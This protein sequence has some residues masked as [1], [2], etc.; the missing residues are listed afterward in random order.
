MALPLLGRGFAAGAV[1]AITAPNIGIS[2]PG[3]TPSGAAGSACPIRKGS[4][5][6]ARMGASSATSSMSA[7]SSAE[8]SCV[9]AAKIG[10]SSRLSLGCEA[11]LPEVASSLRLC[12]GDSSRSLATVLSYTARASSAALWLWRVFCRLGSTPRKALGGLAA[13]SSGLKAGWVSWRLR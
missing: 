10:K 11:F 4:A 5:L 8:A 1:G 6:R 2:W 13:M 9:G 3:G 7:G 12:L